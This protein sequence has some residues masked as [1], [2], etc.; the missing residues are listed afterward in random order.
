VARGAVLLD[1]ATGLPA[2]GLFGVSEL[3]RARAATDQRF[4]SVVHFLERGKQAEREL[5]L[6]VPVAADGLFYRDMR[7]PFM[8]T[9]QTAI[10]GTSEALM[11]PAAFSSLVANYFIVGKKMKIT[12]RGKVTSAA[13][14]PGSL[15]LTARFGTTTSGTSL[16]ASA[17]TALAASK[18]N[19]TWILELWATC[20]AVGSSGSLIAEG[21]FMYD[22]AGALFSTAA[23]NPLLFPASAAAAA[24]VDTTVAAGLVVGCTLG[25]ASDSLTVQELEVEALN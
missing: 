19:I 24:T 9:D 12:A 5:G 7:S 15:T 14:T 8:V 13:S 22:G 3:V 6:N 4:L 17:A 1:P 25:S 2:D 23:N 21:R 18:T 10:T 11:W 20:R 16:A